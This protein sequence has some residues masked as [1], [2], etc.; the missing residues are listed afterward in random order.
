MKM[1]IIVCTLLN[2][3]VG[4]NIEAPLD[5]VKYGKFTNSALK[6]DLFDHKCG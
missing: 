6:A 5:L 1:L 4:S 2:P 3:G